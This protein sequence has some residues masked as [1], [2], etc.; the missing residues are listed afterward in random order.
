MAEHVTDIHT[1]GERERDREDLQPQQ[2]VQEQHPREAL[3]ARQKKGR[4]LATDRDDRNDRHVLLERQAQEPLATPKVDLVPE[5]AGSMDLI[6][7]SRINQQRS[8]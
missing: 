3:A 5:P 4:L 7:S 8:P 2:P 6:V 1:P